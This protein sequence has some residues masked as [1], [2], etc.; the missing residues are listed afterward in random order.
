LPPAVRRY[1]VEPMGRANCT[2]TAEPQKEKGLHLCK[3]LSWPSQT[4]R[5]VL[6]PVMMMWWWWERYYQHRPERDRHV[7]GI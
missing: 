6:A 7:I 4:P 1:S 2:F 3:P 5:F